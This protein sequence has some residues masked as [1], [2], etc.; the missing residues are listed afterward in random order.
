MPQSVNPYQNQKKFFIKN[1]IKKNY[2]SLHEQG[3]IYFNFGH[4]LGIHRL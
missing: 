3:F 4:L 1:K 2:F